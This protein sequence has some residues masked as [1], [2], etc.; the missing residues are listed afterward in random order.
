MFGGCVVDAYT[1]NFGHNNLMEPS[2]E[3]LEVSPMSRT[4]IMKEQAWSQDR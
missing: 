3:G 2:M 1:F 4:T